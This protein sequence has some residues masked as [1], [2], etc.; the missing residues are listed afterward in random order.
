MKQTPIWILA[1]ALI[2]PAAA[3]AADKTPTEAL[4]GPINEVI[5][6][7]KDP[8]LQGPENKEVQRE[9]IMAVVDDLFDFE[10]ISRLALGRFR[11]KLDE[12]QME[13]FTELFTDLLAGTYLK[14]VQKEFQNEEVEY[15]EELAHPTDQERAQVKTIVLRKGTQIPID[16]SM[17]LKDG[18]WR[19]YDVKVEGVSLIKNYRTQFEKI[20]LNDPAEVLIEKLEKKTGDTE[21]NKK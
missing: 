2:L 4:R 1:L 7:L 15:V 12:K 17:Y 9:K 20:L 3:S 10:K 21:E 18:G 8:E 11:K 19:V 6:V 5:A 13:R 14:Q 16:Y